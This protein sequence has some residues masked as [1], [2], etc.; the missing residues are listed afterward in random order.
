MSLE[1]PRAHTRG[2]GRLKSTVDA[3]TVTHKILGCNRAGRVITDYSS[4]CIDAGR[5]GS[6][7]ASDTNIR[8]NGATRSWKCAVATPQKSLPD[9]VGS[10][11]APTYNGP[12]RIEPR[13]NRLEVR[14][15]TQREIGENSLRRSNKEKRPQSIRGVIAYDLARIVDRDRL[16]QKALRWAPRSCA[17]LVIP[18]SGF[19]RKPWG[20]VL[21]RE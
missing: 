10:A 3:I 19:R 11:A 12:S 21:I 15:K 13:H 20:I 16:R 7:T 4:L 1:S 6:C 5:K 9:V 18:P 14:S 8:L 2:P 17:E